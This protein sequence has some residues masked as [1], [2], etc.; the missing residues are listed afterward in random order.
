[1]QRANKAIDPATT[2]ATTD[3]PKKMLVSKPASPCLEGCGYYAL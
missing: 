3:P 2:A 1:M